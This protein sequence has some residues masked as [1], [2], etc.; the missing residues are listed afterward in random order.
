MTTESRKPGVFVKTAHRENNNNN[1]DNKKMMIVII[2]ITITTMV[3]SFNHGYHWHNGC[4]E[5][6]YVYP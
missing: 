3:L 4:T 2:M 1:N 6:N 5:L